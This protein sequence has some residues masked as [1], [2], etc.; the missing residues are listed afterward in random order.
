MKNVSF[1][2]RKKQNRLF[3]QPSRLTPS[4]FAYKSIVANQ[5]HILSGYILFCPAKTFQFI[6]AFLRF[7]FVNISA[8]NTFLY[9]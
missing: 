7:I 1:I 5:N 2:L 8:A 3:G 9:V 4:I 6:Y